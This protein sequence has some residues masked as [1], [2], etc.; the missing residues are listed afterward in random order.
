MQAC[1]T[2]TCPW[3]LHVLVQS[4]IGLVYA[5]PAMVA[6]LACALIVV[7]VHSSREAAILRQ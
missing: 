3:R 4:A 7:L 2:L 6:Q 1:T 5:Q